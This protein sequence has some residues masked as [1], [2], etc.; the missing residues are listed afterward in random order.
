MLSKSISLGLKGIDAIPVVIEVDV[1]RGLPGFNIVGLPDSVIKESKDRIRPAVENSGFEFMPKNFVVNLAPAAFKKQG[2]NFDLA[3]AIAILKTTGQINLDIDKIPMVGELSLTGEVR[4]VRGVISMVLALYEKGYTDVIVPFENRN[5]ASIIDQ[6]N[7][8]PVKSLFETLSVFNGEMKPYACQ[9]NNSDGNYRKKLYDFQDICGQENV[10][11]AIE[12]AAAGHHNILMYGPPGS[13]KSMIAKSIPSILPALEK[14]SS[15]TTTMIHSIAGENIPDG[16]LVVDPPFRSPHHT[17]SDIA[18]VGGGTIPR[19][20]EITLAHN[21]VLF[22]DEFIEFKNDVI[23]ALRQPL[24][25][26]VITVS[27]AAGTVRFPADFMLVASTNP[28]RCG[29]L[30]DDEIECKCSSIQLKKYFGKIAGPI[31]ERFDI[32]IY[33]PRVPYRKLMGKVKSET[34]NDIKERIERTRKIQIKRFAGETIMFNS[35][36]SSPMVKK[37]CSLSDEMNEMLEDSM[38]KLKL[39]ARSFFRVL[40]VARTIADLEESPEIKKEHVFEA[41]SYKSINKYYGF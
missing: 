30:F 25:D 28:C 1:I 22:L 36:M 16:G 37:Y 35:L 7:V 13:G 27:R 26:R 20:G 9:K 6:I 32:E 24:E 17:A 33:V 8:F 4:P 21:G 39:S 11:R 19:V 12:I 38:K 34:S 14:A 15:I 5:E 29:F 23:Q 41:L 40:K 2:A 10:K 3:I 31:L 18:L